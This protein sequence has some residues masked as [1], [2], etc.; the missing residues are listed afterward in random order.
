MNGFRT[1][2]VLRIAE[3]DETDDISVLKYARK[4]RMIAVCFDMHENQSTKLEWNTEIVLRGGQ[5][6]QIDGGP[7]QHPEEAAGKVLMHHPAWSQ[8]FAANAHG[9]ATLTRANSN[10]A[11]KAI[12]KRRTPVPQSERDYELQ[13]KALGARRRKPG[14]GRPG[15]GGRPRPRVLGQGALKGI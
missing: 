7:G 1:E 2:S 8:Q 15:S 14:T 11:T 5:A 12:L 4:H 9:V 10:F 3:I 6:I 13:L